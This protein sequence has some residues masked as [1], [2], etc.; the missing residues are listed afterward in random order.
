MT[1]GLFKALFRQTLTNPRGAGAAVIA[2][3]LPVQGLWIAL[4]LVSVLLSLLVSALFHIAPLPPDEVGAMI[5]MSPAHQAPLLFA[6]INWGQA[7]ISVFVLHWIGQVFG[8][9]G[10]LA[11]MLAV[12]IWLQA[13]TI[14]LAVVLFLAG[15]ILPLIAA[16]MMLVAF[17]WGIWATISLVDAANRFDNLLKATGVCLAALV[18]F[19]V[20]M[21]IISAVIGGLAM[22]R[23]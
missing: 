13:V 12:M 15:L 3:D 22:G 4:M 20:G 23:G 14:V 11:D 16:L 1:F 21:A 2:L 17:V 18:A 19:S 10:R 9:K 6:L 7:V 5:R 8:G